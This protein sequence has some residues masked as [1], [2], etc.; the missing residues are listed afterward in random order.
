MA[1]C[2]QD[3][4]TRTTRV[5]SSLQSFLVRDAVLQVQYPE[6]TQHDSWGA[7]LCEFLGVLDDSVGIV[8]ALQSILLLRL[9]LNYNLL[10]STDINRQSVCTYGTQ[11]NIAH[12]PIASHL[13]CS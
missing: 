12:A 13:A 3:R 1:V 10:V 7:A 2:R 5:T 4:A 8:S 9:S 11:V 6:K